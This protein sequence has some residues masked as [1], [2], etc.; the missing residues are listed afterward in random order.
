MSHARDL[1]S[2]LPAGSNW[3]WLLRNL[4]TGA[5]ERF[6]DYVFTGGVVSSR[7][8][9]FSANSQV[10]VYPS[11]ETLQQ[12]SAYDLAAKTNSIVCTNCFS[13]SLSADGR[14]IA[15]AMTTNR[16]SQLRQIFLFDRLSNELKL[17]TQTPA[18]T[19]STGQSS[20]PRISGDGRFIVF[21]S[22]ARDLLPVSDN[23]ISHLFVWDR[24]SGSFSLVS[25][26]DAATRPAIYDNPL[27]SPNGDAIA[28]A[29]S[30][31]TLTT[32]DFNDS[33]DVFV[34][35]RGVSTDSDHDGLDDAWEI[36]TFGDL[37]QDGNGDP[38]GDGATNLAEWKAGTNPLSAAS[39]FR[40]SFAG[41]I[42]ANTISLKW[43]SVPGKRY[44][45]QYSDDLGK[46]SWTNLGD[47][48]VAGSD[49]ASAN[50]ATSGDSRFYRITL[51]E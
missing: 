9:F 43:S 24:Q 10:F 14:W 17:V 8:G 15:V 3:R 26:E 13:P 23:V 1:V 22:T 36:A 28:F 25:A 50:A 41:A 34:W 18:G 39:I 46:S 32:G 31:S 30:E 38:D 12:L 49:A 51:L 42:G 4:Q 29:S 16:F 20:A 33:T 40:L 37:K 7:K 48:V 21:E 35:T 45:V 11:A 5:T 19:L 27:I 47:P 6:D 2:D 44:Q